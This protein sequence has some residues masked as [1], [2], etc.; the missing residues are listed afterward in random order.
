MEIE[1]IKKTILNKIDQ[2]QESI[3]EV[4]AEMKALEKL[5]KELL[6]SIKKL[7]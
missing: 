7:K 3:S 2:Y 4:N 6:P 5:F 1:N